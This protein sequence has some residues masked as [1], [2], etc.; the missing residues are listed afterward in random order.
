ME[1]NI[2][3][4]GDKSTL[5]KLSQTIMVGFKV[6][7]YNKEVHAFSTELKWTSS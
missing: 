2:K 3:A 7:S 4:Q 6:T 1:E 5:L